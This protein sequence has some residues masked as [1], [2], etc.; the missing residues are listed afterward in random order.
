MYLV[1]STSSVLQL[2]IVR[3]RASHS[4]IRKKLSTDPKGIINWPK[5]KQ[6]TQLTQNTHFLKFERLINRVWPSY[7]EGIIL[8]PKATRICNKIVD[9]LFTESAVRRT[10]ATLYKPHRGVPILKN[11]MSEAPAGVP[12]CGGGRASHRSSFIHENVCFGS[13]ENP[14][15]A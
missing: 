11:C 4:P 12:A 15:F 6:G 9:I 1:L 7:F 13:V 2:Y 3:K 14:L 5:Q 8:F 10:H